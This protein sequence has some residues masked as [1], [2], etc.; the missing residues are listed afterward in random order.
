[1]SDV[2]GIVQNVARRESEVRQVLRSTDARVIS[3]CANSMRLVCDV[4]RLTPS[5]RM[6]IR[7]VDDSL[8]ALKRS[9]EIDI[10][11]CGIPRELVQLV[12]SV[13]NAYIIFVVDPAEAGQSLFANQ[14][15]DC[16]GIKVA[17]MG[18][19]RSE[20]VK[21]LRCNLVNGPVN[22]VVVKIPLFH[23][24][25]EDLDLHT[26][27]AMISWLSL[28]EKCHSGILFLHSLESDPTDGH[29][30]MIQRFESL[31]KRFSS[32]AT[33]PSCVYVVP[34]INLG[35][36]LPDE[37]L[38]QQ[39]SQLKNTIGA[40]NC[41]RNNKWHASIFPEVYK[42]QPETA[43]SAALLLLKDIAE[44]QAKVT[45]PLPKEPALKRMPLQLPD[46]HL[47]LKDLADLLFSNFK[48]RE[49]VGNC[50]VIT[51]GRTVLELTP[52]DHLQRHS[53]LISLAALLFERFQREGTKED[54]DETITLK[55]AASEYISSDDP[56]R[57]TILLELDDCLYERFRR[58]DSIADLEEI[59]SLRRVLLEHTPTPDRCRPLLNLANSLH[60]KFQ[61]QGSIS[62]IN[63]AIN[64]ADA[65]LGLCRPGHAD[66]ALSQNHLASYLE[67]KVSK[68]AAR[69]HA[70]V[71]PSNS[72][73]SDIK[74]F[75]KKVVFE[76]LES[77]PPRLLH[78]RS[79]I[80]C[81]RDAQLSHFER[82]PQYRQLLLSTS[83]P[84]S[85]QLRTE[86]S[87]AVLEFFAFS[88]LSHR[89]GSGEPLLREIEGKNI[90]DLGGKDGRE[91][92][93]RFCILALR[94][95]F[96]WAW[97]DT[98]C[99]DKDSS[100]ELQ[101]AIGSMFSWYRRSS[102]TIVYLS[103]VF[104]AGSLANSVWFRRGWTLQELLASHAILFY[105][106]DWSLYTKSDT[107]NHKTDPT[108]LEELQKATG[109]AEQ[110]LTNFYPGVDDA[111]T[112]LHWASG[113]STT[114]PEDIAYSLFGIFKVHLPVLYGESVEN[115]L[116]RLL[117]EIISRSGDI[118]V[119]DWVGEASSFNSCFPANLLPYQTVPDI[120]VIPSNLA[121][122]NDLGPG[123]G[124]GKEL[125]DKLSGLP[126]AGFANRKLA[127]PSTVHQVTAVKLQSSS[128]SPS[129]YTYE[130]HASRLRPVNVTLSVKLGNRDAYILVRPWHPKSLE[131]QTESDDD[132]VWNLLEQLGQPFIALLLKRLPHNEYKRIASDCEITA[133]V[134]DLASTLDTEVL[135]P[136]I[137]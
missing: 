30:L 1:M 25:R 106:Y 60:G 39:L 107:A 136:E 135:I 104:D 125:Y 114:R 102:L 116:G 21:A 50:G 73:S 37:T 89:W 84:G 51:L 133:C 76:T 53:A 80:L 97:S 113:R 16:H 91:K 78:A 134:Q 20:H 10:C 47:A 24:N 75:I 2:Q 117:A 43:W 127:L 94:R 8:G 131:T 23:S 4:L 49:R 17:E 46:G 52:P 44:I 137:V 128:T 67:T 85:Q 5:L 55:R 92:L 61:K 70:T 99:I 56:Q 40:L 100:A 34:T 22:I 71:V 115:A 15:L 27:N 32:Q 66:H 65:A 14:L 6:G 93:Q 87:D 48:R 36:L 108:V 79:G 3:A 28:S 31:I 96:Q 54:L 38:S 122:R 64:L 19:H 124:K 57:Q 110:H 11:S 42:G 112:R 41:N 118:S 33:V 111:R 29:T 9:L 72:G 13:Q 77:I 126:R 45:T 95:G 121:K 109:V 129:R 62:D 103:D 119:L 88:T 82:S 12:S 18:P 123:K 90:Y 7:T 74:Q 26:E 130:I 58:S 98:C 35:S 101:E 83:P 105:T 81:N 120:Q 86:I 132:A 69:A 59:I 63:E 68:G